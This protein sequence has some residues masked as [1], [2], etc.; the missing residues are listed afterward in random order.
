MKHSKCS[1]CGKNLGFI[2]SLFKIDLVCKKHLEEINY[3]EEEIIIGIATQAIAC[4]DTL[5]LDPKTGMI[6]GTKMNISKG[7]IRN[8]VLNELLKTASNGTWR[9]IANQLKDK[10]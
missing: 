10:I 5:Y 8:E 3:M 4:G 6:R 1:I 2:A 7:K 9:R